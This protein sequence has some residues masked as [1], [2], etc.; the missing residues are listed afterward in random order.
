MLNR[1][2][3][4]GLRIGKAQYDLIE[5]VLHL[6]LTMRA[7]SHE[8]KKD[9]EKLTIIQWHRLSKTFRMRSAVYEDGHDSP[10][11]PGI[12][13]IEDVARLDRFAD[14]T[15]RKADGW[16]EGFH[17]LEALQTAYDLD[18]SAFSLMT[19][20]MAQQ[21]AKY[22]TGKTLEQIFNVSPKNDVPDMPEGWPE[23]PED[24]ENLSDEDLQDFDV[25]S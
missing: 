15:G 1:K 8:E 11:L 7:F 25:V 21:Y 6:D 14:V 4:N 16:N 10:W 22:M 12:A 23:P 3:V 5:R 20:D 13:W 2:I 18:V 24:W 19:L 9:Y 17:S